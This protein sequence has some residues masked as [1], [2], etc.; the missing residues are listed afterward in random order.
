MSWFIG[1]QIYSFW[2]W[3]QFLPN[4]C[5]VSS[6][7][8]RGVCVSD[9]SCVFETPAWSIH[10]QMLDLNLSLVKNKKWN[11][12]SSRSNGAETVDVAF[13]AHRRESVLSQSHTVRSLQIESLNTFGFSGSLVLVDGSGWIKSPGMRI[14]KSGSGRLRF[15]P[16]SES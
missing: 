8:S 2:H 14:I 5:S 15:W 4:Q 13:E 16:Q 3:H 9:H 10:L 12:S 1:Y 6:S 7:Y 11:F